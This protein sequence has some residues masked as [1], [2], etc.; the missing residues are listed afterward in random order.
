MQGFKE[1][2]EERKNLL[3]DRGLLKTMK[4][5]NGTTHSYFEISDASSEMLFRNFEGRAGKMITRN[6][7]VTSPRARYALAS[8]QWQVVRWHRQR[9]SDR[10][11]GSPW[12]SPRNHEREVRTQP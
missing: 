2:S 9:G 6:S 3:R 1:L 10:G 7:S 4:L 11:Q 12:R 5:G 8:I